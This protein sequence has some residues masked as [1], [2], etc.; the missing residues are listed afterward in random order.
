MNAF[1]LFFLLGFVI[2]LVI[3]FVLFV[4][5]VYGKRKEQKLLVELRI[6]RVVTNIVEGA[7]SNK[8]KVDWNFFEVP[9]KALFLTK[10]G[11]QLRADILAQSKSY[12]RV[13]IRRMGHPIPF[14]KPA[15]K[16]SLV[17]RE[18]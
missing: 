16:V 10:G 13:L 6:R 15:F 5:W 9:R 12:R 4:A 17:D 3:I 14:G 18:E 8:G 7:M 1:F 2:G 11:R